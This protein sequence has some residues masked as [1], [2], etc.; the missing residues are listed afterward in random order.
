[1][2]FTEARGSENKSFA[3][4]SHVFSRTSTASIVLSE[5]RSYEKASESKILIKSFTKEEI[6]RVLRENIGSRNMLRLLTMIEFLE[7]RRGRSAS[8]EFIK[9]IILL[10]LLYGSGRNKKEL[11]FVDIVFQALYETLTKSSK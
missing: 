4:Q 5:R 11:A 2:S 8:E 1:M 9:N 7:S 6:M 10:S 3:R